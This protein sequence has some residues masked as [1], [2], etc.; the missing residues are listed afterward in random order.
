MN[1]IGNEGKTIQV[2]IYAHDDYKIF[3]SVISKALMIAMNYLMENMK[4]EN[5][6]SAE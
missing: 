3:D 2:D 1:Y 4:A 5:K 6:E